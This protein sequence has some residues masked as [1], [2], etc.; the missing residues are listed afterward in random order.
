[1]DQ[2]NLDYFSNL[3]DQNIL[4]K[5][6]KNYQIQ[7][8]FPVQK[9]IIPLLLDQLNK[10]DSTRPHDLCVSSPT[11]SGKT[12][13]FALPII[14]HLTK[15]VTK[16]LRV[17]II[18]PITDLAKQ[19]LRI[20]QELC[21][22]LF[23][24]VASAIGN[25]PLET[26]LSTIFI[27]KDNKLVNRADIL[28]ATPGKLIELI[29]NVPEFSLRNVQILVIDE[30]DR[31]LNSELEHEWIDSLESSLYDCNQQLNC[32][33]QNKHNQ[34]LKYS[35]FNGCC[36]ANYSSSRNVVKL[37]F[38]A[39]LNEEKSKLEVLNLFEPLFFNFST[40]NSLNQ[41]PTR[42]ELPKTLVQ[43]HINV[44]NDFKPAMIVYLMKFLNF[45]KIICFIGSKEDAHRLNLL[46]GK[47]K[48]F[49]VF[50][51]SSQ[52]EPDERNRLK[53]DF[54]QGKIDLIICTDILA[55]GIDLQD[56]RCVINY[57]PPHGIQAYVHRVGR[58]ARANHE[59]TAITLVD[60]SE[61]KRFSVIARKT[62]GNRKVANYR[63]KYDEKLFK[64]LCDS[65]VKLLGSLKEDVNLESKKSDKYRLKTINYYKKTQK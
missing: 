3:I 33:C 9:M 11:G 26:D 13:T 36:L 38:S 54:S 64:E 22:G 61:K 62:V 32:D 40:V 12:F 5:L 24:N 29:T 39:T 46:L 51:M 14:Q 2:A 53:N 30:V 10:S 16:E 21:T 49:K 55:R 35:Q 44:L 18:L 52:I 43:K 47:Y 50:E 59:G 19:V 37:L 8:L 23:I 63:L 17:L 58:T 27:K 20:F 31:I 34:K 56:V 57:E 42:F 6:K 41:A 60:P 65:Y 28:I 7:V 4:D 45:R 1:M 15:F 48:E 25:R